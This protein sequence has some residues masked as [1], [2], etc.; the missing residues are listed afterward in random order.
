[1]KTR[2]YGVDRNYSRENFI[3]L[4][5]KIA[6]HVFTSAQECIPIFKSRIYAR[7]TTT[8]T[9]LH[10]HAVPAQLPDNTAVHRRS[11]LAVGSRW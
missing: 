9:L 7:H 10:H 11:V 1:V 4:K 6:S 2:A 5:Y 3:I 8:S